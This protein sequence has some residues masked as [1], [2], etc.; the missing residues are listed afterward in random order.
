MS[1]EIEKLIELVS[2]LNVT[3]IPANLKTKERMEKNKL[4]LE[5]SNFFYYVKCT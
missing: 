1:I 2:I 5:T 3:A 4:E